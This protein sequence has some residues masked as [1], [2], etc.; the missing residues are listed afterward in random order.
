M[1]HRHHFSQHPQRV[2][3]HNEIHARPPEPME[4]PLAI[5]HIVMLTDAAG[6]DASRAHLA[7]LLG[8]HHLP[9]PDAQLTHLRAEMGAFRLR[10]HMCGFE[11]VPPEVCIH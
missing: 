8:D 2:A 11:S 1:P 5:T 6:R 3:L 10:C 4:A 9:L 7:R